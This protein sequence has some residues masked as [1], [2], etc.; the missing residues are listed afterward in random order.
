MPL[1]P[2]ATQVLGLGQA[3]RTRVPPVPLIGLFWRR[4]VRLPSVLRRIVPQTST[5]TQVL[6]LRQA[7]PYRLCDGSL[8]AHYHFHHGLR[9]TGVTSVLAHSGP[10]ASLDAAPGAAPV[11]A[12]QDRV[13]SHDHA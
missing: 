5:A 7:T 8:C 12:P 3:T 11:R 4:Q 1:S 10:L 2:T 13:S 6:G 9:R